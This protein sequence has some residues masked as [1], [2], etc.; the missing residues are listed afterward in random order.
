[1]N[2]N[3]IREVLKQQAD[4]EAA[5][6]A[7]LLRDATPATP[8]GMVK[9][10]IVVYKNHKI[11]LQPLNGYMWVSTMANVHVKACNSREHGM[12]IIDALAATG[13]DTTVGGRLP[14]VRGH[15]FGE[16]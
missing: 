5:I 16:I 12:A 7:E 6:E 2:T 11:W 8:T 14:D 15:M 13:A 10:K 1:M 4:E 3:A 9:P